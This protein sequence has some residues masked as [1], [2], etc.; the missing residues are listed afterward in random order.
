MPEFVSNCYWMQMIE[1]K[2]K[3]L[4]GTG[5]AS[6]VKDSSQPGKRFDTKVYETY[7][8]HIKQQ[9][10]L[11]YLLPSNVRVRF[12]YDKRIDKAGVKV[13]H[14]GLDM[15]LRSMTVS[16]I[17]KQLGIDSYRQNGKVDSSL[18]RDLL[19]KLINE[20]RKEKPEIEIAES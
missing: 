10:A 13:S 2:C 11:A 19:V 6:K 8:V 18:I 12:W 7:L 17:L 5:Q 4:V 3:E 9:E 1:S 20:A 16:S 15:L 14:E